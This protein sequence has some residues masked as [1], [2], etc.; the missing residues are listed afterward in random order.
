MLD[1]NSMIGAN[2]QLDKDEAQY[3][4]IN[5]E[6]EMLVDEVESTL[7]KKCEVILNQLGYMIINSFIYYDKESNILTFEVKK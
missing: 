4:T 1:D 3:L 6:S 2:I 7:F 5:D